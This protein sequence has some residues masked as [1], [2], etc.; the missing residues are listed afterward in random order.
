MNGVI[1]RLK[2]PGVTP[3]QMHQNWM[4]VKLA[5]GWVYGPV[6][7]STQ[8]THPCLLDYSQLG[9]EQRIKDYLFSAVVSAVVEAGAAPELP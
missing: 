5:D 7:D 4:K 1:F 8:K 2:N 6:K 9:P 3:E